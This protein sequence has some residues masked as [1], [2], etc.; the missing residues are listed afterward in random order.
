MPIVQWVPWS[1]YDGALTVNV[2][3]TDQNDAPGKPTVG[4]VATS[5]QAPAD[6]N[7]TPVV[8][9]NDPSDAELRGR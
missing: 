9:P 7:R 1:Q 6:D 4:V 3:V 5:S 8:D 2:E